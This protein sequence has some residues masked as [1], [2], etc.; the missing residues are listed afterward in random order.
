MSEHTDIPVEDRQCSRLGLLWR[1]LARLSSV[2]A[3]AVT[4]GAGWPPVS[5]K[6]EGGCMQLNRVFLG[7]GVRLWAGHEA[8]LHIGNNTF[9]DEGT[10]IIAWQEVN[11]GDN[12]YLGWDVLIVD[13]DLHGVA[14]RPV[15]NKPVRIGHGVR[16][17]CRALILKGVQIGSGATIEP[18]AV[19]TKNVPENGL[20]RAAVAALRK[21]IEVPQ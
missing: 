17:G 16:I 12:C 7:A 19:V 8:V 5:F 6:N 13:T 11:V 9:V 3:S 4:F 21:R 2:D 15:E 10:E 18:G 20:A 14:G 1:T